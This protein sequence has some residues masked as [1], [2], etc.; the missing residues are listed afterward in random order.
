MF[1][2]AGPVEEL[3]ES[4]WENVWICRVLIVEI[5]RHV[6]VV[7]QVPGVYVVDNVLLLSQ[8]SVYPLQ[9][10]K[11]RGQVEVLQEYVDYF[12]W[13]Y[14]CNVVLLASTSLPTL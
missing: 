12:T 2:P 5:F 6:L 8:I 10:V 4:C 9:L 14:Q 1:G 7:V 13:K 11:I 3:G